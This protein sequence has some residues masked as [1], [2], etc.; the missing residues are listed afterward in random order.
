MN[1]NPINQ[2][3]DQIWITS[4][5]LARILGYSRLDKVTQIFNR[6]AD[7]F[8][9]KMTRVIENPSNVNLTLRIFSLRGAHLIAI[10]ARTPVA[11]E[12]RKWVLDVLEKEVLQQQID[13]RVK[14]N[15]EQQAILKEIVDRRCEGN[16]KKRTE[17]W[18]R[19]NQHFRI[20]RYS[21]LL[22]IHFQDAIDYLETMQIKAKGGIHIDE[23]QS[24]EMLCVHARFFQAWWYTHSPALAKL[25]PLLV[26]MLND[27]MFSMSSAI[28]DMSKKCGFTM[29]NYD[30]DHMFELKTL[31]H[32]RYRLL[33]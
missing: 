17:L 15:A 31:P 30:Y 24:L 1:F 28:S 8:T 12:F 33:K 11:K 10:F 13:T 18:S 29:P 14:I 32:E 4:S 25:N 23:K 7:E 20:P 26:S 16:V 5:E 21:E 6:K 22:A 27:N 19:H 3:D 9:S 2:N